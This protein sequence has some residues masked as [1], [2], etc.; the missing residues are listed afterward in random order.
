MY[1]KL[2]GYIDEAT[3][4]PIY[5]PI[6]R[7]GILSPE[8][9]VGTNIDVLYPDENVAVSVRE[10]PEQILQKIAEVKSVPP[11]DMTGIEEDGDEVVFDL[12]SGKKKRETGTR[13]E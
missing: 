10:K 13:F 2:T 7:M 11:V 5:I 6:E 3:T 12:G 9:K 1:I 4:R 8:P